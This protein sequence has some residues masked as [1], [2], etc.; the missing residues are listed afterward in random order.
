MI[1]QELWR[2]VPYRLLYYVKYIPTR[3]YTRFQHSLRIINKMAKQLIDQ[4]FAA[5]LSGG[6]SDK[7]V[8]SVLGELNPD[9]T[10]LLS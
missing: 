7:D 6:N 4:K 1:F 2:Y 9:G 8:M 5:L 10:L 3:E